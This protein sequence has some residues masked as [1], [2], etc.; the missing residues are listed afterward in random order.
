MKLAFLLPCLAG[1]AGLYLARQ[2]GDGT[3]GFYAATVATA[4]VYA[5]AWWR[6]GRRERL[7]ARR[8]ETI[9]LDIGVGVLLGA[10]LAVVFVAG[11]VVVSHVPALAQPATQLLSTTDRG[12]LAPT[13]FVLIINGVTEELVYRDVVPRQLLARRV[14]PTARAAGAVAVAVYC[15]VT[16]AMGVALLILAAAVIGAVAQIEASRTGRLYSPIALHL[17][18]SI[19]MLL[20]LP[21]FFN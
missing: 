16:I 7:T 8:F 9:A 1:A 10:I 14:V 19:G 15:V 20:I 2:A 5:A 18:W 12:G 4:L 13:L 17:T 6:W 3:P 11:A 21:F